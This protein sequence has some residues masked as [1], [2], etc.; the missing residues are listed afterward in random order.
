[1][2]NYKLFVEGG[3]DARIL[4][5]ACRNGFKEFL[6]KAGLAGQMPRV[7]ACG[8]RKAAYDDFCTALN[9]GER[10]FLL[11]DS[12]DPVCSEYAQKPWQHLA[13]RPGDQWKQPADA[14]DEQCHRM[15]VCM[16][17]WFLADRQI[18]AFFFGQGFHANALPAPS[19]AVESIAKHQVH[20]ALAKATNQCK[21]KGAYEKGGHSFKLL[22][23]L[24]PDAVCAASPWARRFIEELKK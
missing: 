16:E 5:T 22:A 7:I 24:H 17:S 6:K 3:G 9:A 21:T 8:S 2:V 20:D 11:V 14:T 15:V 12:E 19:R 23:L 4:R 18:L 1:M 13:E 10:A